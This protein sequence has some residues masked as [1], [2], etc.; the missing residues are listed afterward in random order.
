[1]TNNEM[2][3]EYLEKLSELFGESDF[4]IKEAKEKFEEWGYGEVKKSDGN[5]GSGWIGLRV[6]GISVACVQK[7]CCWLFWWNCNSN[8]YLGR[9]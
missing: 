2:K 1:M 9:W 4:T 8:N 5:F 7:F 3:K 6:L